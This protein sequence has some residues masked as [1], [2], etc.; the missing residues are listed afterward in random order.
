MAHNFEI[1]PWQVCR[2]GQS[3]LD[4]MLRLLSITIIFSCVTGCGNNKVRT[5]QDATADTS[6]V[7]VETRAPNSSFSPAFAGQTRVKAV[8]TST[9]WEAIVISRELDRPWGLCVLPDGRLLITQ[10]SGTFRIATITGELSAPISGI[11]DVNAGGQGG[12]LDI[13]L[14]PHF[15]QNHLIYWTFSEHT[16]NG[17]L[18]AVGKGKLAADEKSIEGARVIYRAI[19]AYDGQ[20]HYGGRILFDSAGNLFVSTG[21]RSDLQTR[22][23][24]QWLNSALGKVLRITRDGKAAPGNPFLSRKDALP[25]LYSYGHRNVQ[26]LAIHPETGDLWEAEFGPRGG[27][28]LN[29]IE[30]GKNYGWPIITYGLEYSGELVGEGLTER[31]GLEQPIY[32]WD[33]VLSP[34]GMS[35]CTGRGFPEWKNDL[36]ICGL[37]SNHIARLVIKNNRVVGEERLLSDAGQRFRAITEGKDGALYA[38]TDEGHLYR[39]AKK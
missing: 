26:S 9:P 34:S 15:A 19:P 7:S 31:P 38:V 32:Y 14:D 1:S 28:E 16:G 27:D 17:N 5:A 21:E 3:K 30:A 22:P 37:N 20:L 8:H 24:A 18:T 2:F 29:K 12:L 36:F 13:V 10:K 39:I 35:F 23:Q 33:P 4:D 11:P 6:G 25:E